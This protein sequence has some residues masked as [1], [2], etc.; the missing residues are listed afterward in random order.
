MGCPGRTL[1]SGWISLFG[2][3]G[4]AY[5]KQAF[6]TAA[7]ELPCVP[8][9][10]SRDHAAKTISREYMRVDYGLSRAWMVE[11]Y[12]MIC[13]EAVTRFSMHKHLA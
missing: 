5:E 4:H 6:A 2:G 10:L 12:R 8:K 7:E 1:Q 11:A 3:V 13:L 9:R